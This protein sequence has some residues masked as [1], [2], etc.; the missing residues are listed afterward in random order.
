MLY[1]VISLSEHYTVQYLTLVACQR[2]W[3]QLAVTEAAAGI[4][5]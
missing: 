4:P 1:N 2:W 3:F 5:A